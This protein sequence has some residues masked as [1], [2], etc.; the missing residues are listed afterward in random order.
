M[1]NKLSQKGL[2]PKED[3]NKKTSCCSVTTIGGL[4]MSGKQSSSL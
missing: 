3:N 2:L 1:L 4:G